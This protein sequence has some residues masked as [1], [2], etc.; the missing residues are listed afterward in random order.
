MVGGNGEVS[1][2]GWCDGEGKRGLR[3]GTGCAGAGTDEW[4]VGSDGL[5]GKGV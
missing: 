4:C 5:D 3:R 2:R 1:E